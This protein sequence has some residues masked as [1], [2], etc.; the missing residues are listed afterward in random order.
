MT[1]VVALAFWAGRASTPE[2]DTGKKEPEKRPTRSAD[3]SSSSQTRTPKLVLPGAGGEAITT[4]L[5]LRDFY[6]R[7]GGNY[8]SGTAMANAALSKMNADELAVLVTDLAEAQ[9]STPGYAYTLEI[10]TACAR[11]A[12]VDPDAA[13]R[14]VLSAKQASFRSAAIGNLLA[15]IAAD[16]PELAQAKL[17]SIRDPQLRAAARTG[18]CNALATSQ[19]DAWL[20]MIKND[21]SLARN[22]S[23][24]GIVGEWAVDDPAAAAKRL[25][26]LPSSVRGDGISA[27]AKIWASKDS[28]AA[29]AWA[30]SLG[31]DS[32]RNKALGAIAG[33]MAARDPDGALATLEGMPAAARRAGLS[34]IFQ[35]LA[36]QDFGSAIERATSLSDPTDQRNAILMLIGRDASGDTYYTRDASQI[37]AVIGKLPAGAL[38]DQ[39]LDQLGSR[40]ASS[41]REESEAILQG[42]SAAERQKVE[43]NMVQSLS[44]YDPA[45]ALEI[46]DSLPTGKAESYT[47]QSIFSSLASKD[48]EAALKLALSRKNPVEQI[49]A[50]SSAL[51]QMANSNP[52]A[53]QRQFAALPAGPAREAALQTMASSWGSS[54]AEAAMRWAASLPA[55]ERTKATLTLIPSMARNNPEAAANAIVPFLS[56]TSKN[57]NISNAVSQV[58]SYWAAQD[59]TAATQWAASLPDGTIKDS[60]IQSIAYSWCGKDPDGAAKWI[61]SMPDGKTRDNAVNAMIS[62]TQQN[63]PAT[64]YRW[65]E[66]I[67]DDQHR[68]SAVSN[69]ISN[70]AGS[71]PA[72]ARAAA[73]KADLPQEQRANLLQGLESRGKSVTPSS[74]VYYSVDPFLGQ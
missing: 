50:V 64:A 60:T 5:Q 49:R 3:R 42:Y 15:G 52:E 33:G 34:S 7:S 12:A 9:A 40:L 20:D 6:K 13:L 70:W 29:L 18:L 46:Y 68:Y 24:T 2:S 67:N 47:F 57:P 59:P 53:A 73:L 8:E 63:D 10:S 51:G 54:D 61:D 32:Q 45:R 72:A 69:V 38:R 28:T 37:A 22:I 31:N 16:N 58:S 1:S 62:T 43:K 39:A 74:D 4:A 41:S 26:L 71:D 36:D 65:A 25:A 48:P 30:N 55:E 17:A 23:V 35:T 56:D 27:L 11:W 66:S 44:Y 14:F 21:P 19:P